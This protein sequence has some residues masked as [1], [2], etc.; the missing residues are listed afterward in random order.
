MTP[1]SAP[2]ATPPVAS[3]WRRLKDC[4]LAAL[5]FVV[6]PMAMS[7][8][9]GYREAKELRAELAQRKSIACPTDLY[10]LPFAFSAAEPVDLARPK[11]AKLACF[12]SK[13]TP[14]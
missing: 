5:I 12:Y 13:R 14:S 2:T 1:L 10:G 6:V 11:Y 7:A 3:L 4:V 8:W 9:D